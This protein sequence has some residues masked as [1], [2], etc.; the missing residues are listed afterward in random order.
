MNYITTQTSYFLAMITN[1]NFKI[2]LGAAAYQL[3]NTSSCTI[4]EVKQR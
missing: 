3:E 1:N 2:P 4:T